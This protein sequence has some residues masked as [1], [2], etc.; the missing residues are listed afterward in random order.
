MSPLEVVGSALV[1]ASVVSVGASVVL[2]GSSVVRLSVLGPL[3][4]TSMASDSVLSMV[5]STLSIISASS[6]QV[7]TGRIASLTRR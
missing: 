3:L 2:V 4:G 7:Y 5:A 6:S 1:G